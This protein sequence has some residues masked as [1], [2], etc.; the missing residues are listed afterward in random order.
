[1][2][3]PPITAPAVAP[4]FAPAVA[5]V[6]PSPA[7]NAPAPAVASPPSA[8]AVASTLSSSSVC[9]ASQSGALIF[10]EAFSSGIRPDPTLTISEW[11][12]AHRYLPRKASS[13]PGKYRTSRAPYL[14]EIMDV[15]SPTD[16]TEDI[17]VMK[18]TQ[19]GLTEVGNNLFGYVADMCP[20]PMMMV[21]PTVELAKGHSQQ[22]LVPTIEETPRLRGKVSES[23]SRDSKNTILAKDFPGGALFLTGSNSAAALRH[24]TIRFLVLDDLDGFEHNVGDEGDP[25]DIAEKRTDTYGSRKKIYRNGSPTTKGASRI[26]RHYEASDQRRYYVPCPH[27]LA[28]QTLEFGGPTTDFGIKFTRNADGDV[29]SAAYQCRHC[30]ELIDE[31]H[32]TWMLAHGEWR[33]THPGRRKRGYQVSSLYSPLGWVSWRQNRPGIHRGQGR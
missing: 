26:A 31:H 29:L 32:K 18:G 17:S 2:T 1:M 6:S 4:D 19:L 15:L 9:P 8:P 11:A 24:K 25:S 12:D 10:L 27:C 16:P 23:R 30:H 7:S 14:R 3:T 20:G 21:F 33:A 13:E 28:A 22:K 5:V